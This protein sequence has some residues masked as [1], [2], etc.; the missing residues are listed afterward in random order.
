MSVV[1][2]RKGHPKARNLQHLRIAA[3]CRSAARRLD[4][5]C[6]S[7]FR[8]QYTVSGRGAPNFHRRL[9]DYLTSAYGERCFES[10][11]MTTNGVSHALDMVVSALTEPGDVVLMEE[12]SYF[13][14]HQIFLDHGT[15][16]LG[17]V[18]DA[19]GLDT[20]ALAQRLATGDLSQMRPKLCYLVP[21]HGNPHGRSLSVERRRHLV[22]LAEEHDFLI[23]A[24][25][26]YHLLDWSAS[27]PCPR[28]L[29][30]DTVYRR[31]LL[32]SSAGGSAAQGDA[33]DQ[34]DV[35][36]DDPVYAQVT[37]GIDVIRQGAEEAAEG[38]V[39]S[40]SSFTKI[41]A[42]ALRL[43]WIE[44]SPRLIE[45][46]SSRGY[47]VS[48][49][50]VAPFVS[51]IV[52]ELLLGGSEGDAD[53]CTPSTGQH[54]VMRELTADYKKSC[55]ALC[56]AL[57]AAGCFEFHEPAGGFF[58]W[59]RLPAGVTTDAL[60]PVAESAG[61]VFLP[62]HVCAPCAPMGAYDRH[63]RLCF[64]LLEPDELREGVRRL[65]AAVAQVQKAAHAPE[66]RNGANDGRAVGGAPKK[67]RHAE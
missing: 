44:T 27:G 8:L 13:L 50:G 42:P 61:V 52:S 63:L 4:D 15:R 16:V 30:F 58:V 59:V 49:G 1:D 24:D 32:A 25:E 38:H 19:G 21:A 47:I 28:L 20:D 66:E 17:V 57:R 34:D 18:A 62:G 48:G 33:K 67:P 6:E 22:R 41:L 29:C 64:A 55:T 23:V 5:R 54:A 45:R 65:A 46:I 11:L 39:I 12:P 14:A 2:L 43:G 56:A 37:K 10:S 60:L 40:I 9:A 7:T 31:R 35:T 26:V 36:D 53:A 51:E 3:A